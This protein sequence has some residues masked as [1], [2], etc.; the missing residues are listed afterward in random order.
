[1]NIFT[2]IEIKINVDK[3]TI[4][5]IKNIREKYFQKIQKYFEH[6]NFKMYD[7]FVRFYFIFS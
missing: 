6:F 2:T 4:M 1:M 5:N 7:D 3:N